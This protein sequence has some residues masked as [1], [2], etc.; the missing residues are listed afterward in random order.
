MMIPVPPPYTSG[1]L[2]SAQIVLLTRVAV[3]VQAMVGAPPLRSWS[4]TCVRRRES[5]GQGGRVVGGSLVP[6]LRL[7]SWHAVYLLLP[8][9]LVGVPTGVILGA[10]AAGTTASA[11]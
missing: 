1:G 6:V 3:V 9:V 2:A 11:R 8:G 4:G 5:G 10:F 7:G